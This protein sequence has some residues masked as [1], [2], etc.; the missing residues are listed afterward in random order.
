MMFYD[1]KALLFEIFKRNG[2]IFVIFGDVTQSTLRH[3][4]DFQQTNI[5]ICQTGHM[6]GG[7][8]A[9]DF[10]NIWG[11]DEIF[12]PKSSLLVQIFYQI[13]NGKVY[14]LTHCSHPTRLFLYLLS[15]EWE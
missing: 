5:K 4:Q 13:Q 7:K 9:M 2:N 8:K 11:A 1:P 12:C 14:F 15:F 6:A 10:K 3:R